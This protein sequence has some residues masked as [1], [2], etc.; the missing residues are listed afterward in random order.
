MI[1]HA[2]LASL[3]PVATFCLGS[4]RPAVAED[5]VKINFEAIPSPIVLH[6]RDG[7]HFRDPAAI[8]DDGTFYVYFTINYPRLEG[9]SIVSVTGMTTSKDLIHW[10]D[11]KLLTPKEP[12]LNYSSPGNVIR[13]GGRWH[14]NL[15][16]YP[17][18]DGE[19]H[20]N[21]D[22]R[23]FAMAGDDLEHWDEPT[24]SI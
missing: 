16:T 17:T 6:T 20:R 13:H 19:I 11:V 24:R 3:I 9:K 21:L 8:Y 22:A 10:S 12:S 23:V 1:R 7:M 15:Q 4:I 5:D 2:M 18:P 14:L